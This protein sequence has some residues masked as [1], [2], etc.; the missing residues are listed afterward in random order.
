[1][2]DSRARFRH[3]LGVLR[4]KRLPRNRPPPPA[5]KADVVSAAMRELGVPASHYEALLDA[6]NKSSTLEEFK[7]EAAHLL[8]QGGKTLDTINGPTSTA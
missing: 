6:A 2:G 4:S 7:A 3:K 1:M 5:N 8:S